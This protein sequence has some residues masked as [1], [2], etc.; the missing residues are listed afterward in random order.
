MRAGSLSNT[1]VISLLNGYFVPVFLSNEDFTPTGSAASAEKAELHRIFQEGYAAKLSVGTVHAYVLAPDGHLIDS[2]HVAQASRS[3]NL[4]G[5]LERDVKKLGTPAGEP[6]VKPTAP[7]AP[8]PV[9][10]ALLL[11]L[12][13]RYLQP[14]GEDYTL[15]EANEGWASLP[16]EDWITLAPLEWK[17]LLPT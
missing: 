3:E 12:I 2:M 8:R 17:Q 9:P 13:A 6:V 1:Q 5:M 7:A 16:S 14:K 11:H 10:D 15:V 4:I